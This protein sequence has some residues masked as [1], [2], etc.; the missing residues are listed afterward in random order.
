MKNQEA[1]RFLI[2][3]LGDIGE[4]V[5]EFLVRMPNVDQIYTVDVADADDKLRAAYR[6]QVGALH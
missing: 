5:L 6:A 3:G 1:W 4:L 2:V